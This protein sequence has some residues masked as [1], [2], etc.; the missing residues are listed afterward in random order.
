MLSRR[1]RRDLLDVAAL[2]LR[3]HQ[4]VVEKRRGLRALVHHRVERQPVPRARHRHVKQAALFLNMKAALRLL[5]LHQFRRGIPAR[6]VFLP[7][8]IRGCTSAQ[9]V[10]VVEFQPLRRVHGHQLHRVAGFLL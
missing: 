6:A 1:S 2:D 9:H 7:P 4:N 10:D 3:V 8:G 5:F